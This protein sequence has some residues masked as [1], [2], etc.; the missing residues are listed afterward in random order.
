MQTKTKTS[1][2]DP[3]YANFFNSEEIKIKGKLG[4]IYSFFI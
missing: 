2:T 3:L 1:D 4:V